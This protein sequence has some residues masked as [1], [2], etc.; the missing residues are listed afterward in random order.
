MLYPDI[1]SYC[2]ISIGN[3]YVTQVVLINH[4]WIS[5]TLQKGW[6]SEFCLFFIKWGRV[7]F[8]P[9][10]GE[11]GKIVEEWR[12]LRENNLCLLVD[13]CVY[14]SKKHCNPRY[15]Y[16]SNKYY[17]IPKFLPNI[18]QTLLVSISGTDI[19]TKILPVGHIFSL[20]I[21]TYL[22]MLIVIKYLNT[23]Q[24][25][26]RLSPH[27]VKLSSFIGDKF[28]PKKGESNLLLL[29]IFV[30]VNPRNFMI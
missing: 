19:S 29:L 11:F 14:K 28:S 7:H 27:R 12:F 13:L 17:Y 5:L 1:F 16:K 23:K 20:T 3:K 9:K 26:A 30:F 24:F 25:P 8:S 4:S 21:M 18:L 10:K 6:E 2:W 22:K 15:I